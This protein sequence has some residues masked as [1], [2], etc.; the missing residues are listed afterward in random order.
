MLFIEWPIAGLFALLAFFAGIAAS[1]I[2]FAAWPM[3]VPLLVIGLGFDIRLAIT[4]SLLV[5]CANAAIITGLGLARKTI[6]VRLGAVLALVACVFVV[7]GVYLSGTF[8]ADN[9]NLLKGNLAVI[10]L[11]I[12]ILFLKKG[13]NHR[14]VASADGAASTGTEPDCSRA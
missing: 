5:D 8:L 11:V 9:Q 10:T 2:G 14:S 13:R 3:L 7:P 4:L 1:A 6:V 12:G